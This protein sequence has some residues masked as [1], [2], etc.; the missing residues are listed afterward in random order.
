MTR[1]A[2]ALR[3][4][5]R[6]RAVRSREE[7]SFEATLAAVRAARARALG[8]RPRPT[9]AERRADAVLAEVTAVRDASKRLLEDIRR[10]QSAL[11]R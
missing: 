2:K 10:R 4:V 7:L 9:R 1:R 3:R 8:T 5:E 6:R 11:G